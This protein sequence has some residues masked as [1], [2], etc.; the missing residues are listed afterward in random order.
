MGIGRTLIYVRLVESQ[1]NNELERSSTVDSAERSAAGR[2][3]FTTSFGSGT[4]SRLATGLQRVDDRIPRHTFVQRD[5]TKDGIKG[6]DSERMVCWYGQALM[7]GIR[8]F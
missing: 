2:V 8:R 4:I 7:C 3:R 1:L 5:S 6:S